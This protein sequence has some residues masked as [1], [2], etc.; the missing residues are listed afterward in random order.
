MQNE[1]W[2]PGGPALSEMCCRGRASGRRGGIGVPDDYEDRFRRHEA[3]MESLARM[4]AAQHDFNQRQGTINERLTAAIERIDQTL[5]EV[6]TTQA[7]IK[8]L[9]AHMIE[10]GEN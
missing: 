7:D 10:H 5:A 9:L 3:I 8:T 6:K 2:R 4:L 1:P